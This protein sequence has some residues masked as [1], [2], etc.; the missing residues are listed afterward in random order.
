M[1]SNSS[2]CDFENGVMLIETVK[3]IC[4]REYGD[5]VYMQM[6][7][8]CCYLFKFHDL[9]HHHEDIQFWVHGPT[10][11]MQHLKKS[12]RDIRDCTRRAA[13]TE[14]FLS[15]YIGDR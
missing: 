11:R 9:L 10:Q 5:G 7:N 4:T 8:N 14:R 15:E 3:R 13:V 2:R 1:R 12:L 6:S